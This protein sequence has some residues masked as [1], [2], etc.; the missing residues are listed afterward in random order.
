MITKKETKMTH[1]PQFRF[2]S[3]TTRMVMV[4]F[5]IFISAFVWLVV[6]TYPGFFLFNPF[7]VE[8]SARAAVLTLTTVGWI[9]LALAPV[10]IFSFYA[11]GYRNSLRALPIAALIW[12]VSLVVNHI[13]LFIQD[14]KIY[15]GYLLDYPI[16]IATDILLPVLLVTIW[17][18]LRHPAHPV[19]KHLAPKS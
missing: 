9:V 8:N 3:V 12:P 18:E 1:E 19:H 11:A 7:A 16:F 15:T 4:T 13:S 10:T 6:A 17:F 14:G 2:T 5:G